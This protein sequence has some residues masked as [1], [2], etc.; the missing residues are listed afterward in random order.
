MTDRI[1]SLK[2][3][4]NTSKDNI[5]GLVSLKLI[6]PWQKCSNTPL[7]RT[8]HA[9]SLGKYTSLE[10]FGFMQCS[11]LLVHWSQPLRDSC[12]CA[13]SPA[14]C[15]P[16]ASQLCIK[17]FHPFCLQ[18]CPLLITLVLSASNL[19]THLQTCISSSLENCLHASKPI[20]L[21]VSLLNARLRRCQ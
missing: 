4:F 12:K 14:W 11:A 3:L 5:S 19:Y 1:S 2:T 8:I 20:C 13:S 10:G 6:S 21:A 7:W 17:S 16:R 9:N 15:L 18:T